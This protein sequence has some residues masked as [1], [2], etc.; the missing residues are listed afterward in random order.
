M[1]QLLLATLWPSR[2]HLLPPRAKQAANP[3]H[4]FLISL[5]DLNQHR[6]L[7]RLDQE[8]KFPSLPTF[9]GC[10]GWLHH[11]LG[12][13]NLSNPNRRLPLGVAP[14]KRAHLGLAVSAGT[15]WWSQQLRCDP[16]G[17]LLTPW[18]LRAGPQ[19]RE[20]PR[21]KAAST[22]GLTSAGPKE[23]ENSARKQCS[24]Q[25]CCHPSL[26]GLGQRV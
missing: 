6:A 3:I 2:A 20:V 23:I 18:A 13:G 24:S 4:P 26:C 17:K 5:G 14:F 15:A 21:S 11:V 7:A 1:L 25:S 16:H 8:S 22:L 10:L 12:A 9:Y 19:G